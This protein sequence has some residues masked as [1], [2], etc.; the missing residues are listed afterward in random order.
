ME[1]NILVHICCAP[2]FCYVNECLKEKGYN[3]EG[4]FY[5][6]NIHP[7]EEYEKRARA[8]KKYKELKNVKIIFEENS[9]KDIEEWARSAFKENIRCL[10]CYKIRLYK[11]AIYAKEK[12]FD[13]FT[14]T[15]LYSIY[16][17]HEE[18]KSI[19]EKI[20]KEIK[21]KFYYEDFRKGWKEGIKISKELGLYRQKYCGCFLSEFEAKLK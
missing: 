6:P 15:L 4:F 5:N 12:N 11:T 18:I 9:I 8:L 20:S 3:V 1:M 2:C 13:A 16:Q 7:K 10:G 19:A 14:T 17:K 21:I